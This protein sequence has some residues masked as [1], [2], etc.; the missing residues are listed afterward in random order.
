LHIAEKKR[1]DH[2]QIHGKGGP[3]MAKKVETKAAAKAPAKKTAKKP[4]KAAAKKK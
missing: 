4:A 3:I 2:I 1:E